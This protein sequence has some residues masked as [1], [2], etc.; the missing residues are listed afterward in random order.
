MWIQ[1]VQICG[2]SLVV[3]MNKELLKKTGLKKG[4]YV[5]IMLENGKIIIEPIKV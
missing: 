4:D 3:V 2:H 5:K 1:K